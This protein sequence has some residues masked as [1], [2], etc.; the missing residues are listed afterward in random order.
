MCLLWAIAQDGVMFT[1]D[2]DS[3]EDAVEMISGAISS[4]DTSEL[5]SVEFIDGGDGDPSYLD[6]DFPDVVY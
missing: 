2:A 3:R 5:Y 4:G 1:V 6:D